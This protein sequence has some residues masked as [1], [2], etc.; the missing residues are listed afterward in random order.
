MS[1]S[2]PEVLPGASALL[3]AGILLAATP[4]FAGFNVKLEY[5]DPNGGRVSITGTAAKYIYFRRTLYRTPQGPDRKSYRDDEVRLEAF[6]FRGK[7]VSFQQI[8]EIRFEWR[9]EAGKEVL[10]L[11]FEMTTGERFER[12][13]ADLEG[14]EHPA[15]PSISFGT[16]SGAASIPLDPLTPAAARKGHAGLVR[17]EFPENPDRRRSPRRR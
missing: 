1:S 6:S 11:D 17:M 14:A 12:R 9:E 2:N 10:V 5:L 7:R 8:R 4:A 3:L 15:S 13:G 16:P